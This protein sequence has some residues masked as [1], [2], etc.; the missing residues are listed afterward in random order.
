MPS[1]IY[2]LAFLAV[3]AAFVFL[4]IYLI[5]L[6]KNIQGTLRG[7]DEALLKS[8]A[9]VDNTLAQFNPVVSELS[10]LEDT[11]RETLK[12]INQRLALVEN[13]LTPLLEE[14]KN[15]AKAYQDLG[16]TFERDL[17]P[18]LDNVHQI[19]RNIQDLTGDIKV[20]VQQTQDFFE[21]AREAGETVRIATDIGRSGLSG[22]AVQMASMATGI[23]TSLEFLSENLK[24][25]GGNKK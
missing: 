20:K 3:A 16:K 4:V 14:L 22:L 11:A 18:I 21:A 9:A 15:T 10:E 7:F 12:E 8:Q 23:K 2:S 1:I 6:S 25:K 24:L 13:E 17:P 19:S 5:R